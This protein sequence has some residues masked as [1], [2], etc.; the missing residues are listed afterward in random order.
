MMWETKDERFVKRFALFPRRI[1]PYVVWLEWFYVRQKYKM[2]KGHSWYN[3]W[4][5][6]AEYTREEYKEY[7]KG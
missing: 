6:I 7:M 4:E 3:G 2:Y 5:T 1:G